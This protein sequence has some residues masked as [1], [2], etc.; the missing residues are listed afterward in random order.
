[1]SQRMPSHW[2]AINRNGFTHGLTKP[3]LKSV[4]LEHVLPGGEIGV[5]ATG[6]YASSYPGE[7]D[8][9]FARIVIIALNQIFRMFRDPRMIRRDVVWHEI[10]DQPNIPLG[11]F[12]PRHRESF[13]APQMFV[14]HIAPDAIGRS[15]VVLLAV[16]RQ[17]PLEIVEQILLPI[18]DD[19]PGG[20]PLPNSHQ[21]NRIESVCR[22]RIPFGCRD[23][24]QGDGV[25]PAGA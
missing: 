6:K 23:R 19:D 13:G 4:Q 12:P 16:I 2:L 14:H 18:G 22:K 3:R 1:M 24:A 9:V 5:A 7:G 21:P 20:T 17:R 8:R 10:K 11:E 15:H 25:S